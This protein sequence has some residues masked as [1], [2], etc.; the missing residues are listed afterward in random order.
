MPLKV[1]L[2]RQANSPNETGRTF[3]RPGLW[4]ANNDGLFGG[5]VFG[6]PDAEGHAADDLDFLHDDLLEF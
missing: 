3:V 4:L 1:E 5:H 6:H 2:V